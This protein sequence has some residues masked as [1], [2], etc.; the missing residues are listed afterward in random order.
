[1]YQEEGFLFSVCVTVSLTHVAYMNDL[2]TIQSCW[3]R[4]GQGENWT[5]QRTGMYNNKKKFVCTSAMIVFMVLHVVN[6]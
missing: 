4:R 5:S 1:M 3:K 6:L 2:M